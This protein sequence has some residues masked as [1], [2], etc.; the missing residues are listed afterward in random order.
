MADSIPPH[1]TEATP[2]PIITQ[3]EPTTTTTLHGVPPPDLLAMPT[4]PIPIVNIEPSTPITTEPMSSLTRSIDDHQLPSYAE[5]EATPRAFTEPLET[6]PGMGKGVETGEVEVRNVEGMPVAAAAATTATDAAVEAGTGTGERGISLDE[7]KEELVAITAAP[8]VKNEE[9]EGTE[10][11]QEEGKEKEVKK[12]KKH[13]KDKKDKKEKKD[14][15]DKKDKKGSGSDSS[16]S[17][18][19]DSDSD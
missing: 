6:E 16:S 5:T 18:S 2:A 11:A 12:E 9:A 14:K 7:L 8:E 17:S 13:K 15:K 10:K 1:S 19:S 4:E 3:T